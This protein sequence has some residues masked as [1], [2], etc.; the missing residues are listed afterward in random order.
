[1]EIE[2]SH[3]DPQAQ[4]PGEALL[5]ALA[6]YPPSDK[7]LFLAGYSELCESDLNGKRAMEICG[8]NGVLAA[9]V[10][11]TFP[12]AEIYSLD[13]FRASGPEVEERLER[14]PGLSYVAGDAMDLSDYDDESFDLIWGQAALHHLAHNHEKLSKEVL[15]VL[16]PGGRLVFV[17]EPLGHNLFVSAIRAARVSWHGFYDESNLFFT[18]FEE[19]LGAGF[20][21]CEVQVFNFTGYPM[22]TL[23]SRAQFAAHAAEKVDAWLFRKIP[24]LMKFAANCNVIFTK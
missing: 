20:S 24:G 22:K 17:F 18:Q 14:L 8:G 11:E 19:M 16:K 7:S 5:G 9:M 21:R 3:P 23:S 4:P 10:A 12:H 6:G 2:V 13:L 1:M 15:R